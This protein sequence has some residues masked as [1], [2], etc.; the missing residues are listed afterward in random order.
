M[1]RYRGFTIGFAFILAGVLLYGGTTLVS[2]LFGPRVML[3]TSGQLGPGQPAA[4]TVPHEQAAAPALQTSGVAAAAAR[5]FT[6]VTSAQAKRE[7]KGYTLEARLVGK[8]GK[9]IANTDIAF[10]DVLQL[11]GTREM[12]IAV[13]KTDGYGV[14]TIEYLPASGGRH[15]INVRPLQWDRLAA[16]QATA[17]IDAAR[18][19][20]VVYARE[21]LPLDPFSAR[22]PAIGTAVVA[23][24][25]GLFAFVVLGSAYLIP[26]G[27]RSSP[28]MG[29]ARE[30]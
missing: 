27:K 9:A 6:T 20:P 13:A 17:T 25:W 3:T 28:Y 24:I 7:D 1:T 11:L 22:L 18:V 12:L 29:K 23:V 26:R 19:A 2:G 16:T 5:A 15:T 14:A 10:Y 21:R 8:D 30:V 4:P